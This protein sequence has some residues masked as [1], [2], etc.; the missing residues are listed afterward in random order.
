MATLI[1]I[2]NRNCFLCGYCDRFRTCTPQSAVEPAAE[3][4]I[5]TRASGCRFTTAAAPPRYFN[6]E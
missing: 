5:Y 1:R 3:P 2:L 4:S 6:L